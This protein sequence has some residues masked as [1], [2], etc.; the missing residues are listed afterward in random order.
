MYMNRFMTFENKSMTRLILFRIKYNT[1][2]M[3]CLFMVFNATFINISALSCRS[4]LLVEETEEKY[5]PVTI[6]DKVYH[7]VLYRVH[8]ARVGFE[9]TTLVVNWLH[10]QLYIQLPYDHDHGGLNNSF[11]VDQKFKMSFSQDQRQSICS[12]MRNSLSSFG[13]ALKRTN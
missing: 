9:L 4:V 3:F 10:M 1:W 13:E 6:T 5:R 11:G 2:L 12:F 7:I 8:L